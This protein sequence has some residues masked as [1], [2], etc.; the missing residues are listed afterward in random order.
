MRKL[1]NGFVFFL[2]GIVAVLMLVSFI[3]PYLSP[4]KYPLISILSLGVPILIVANIGFLIY[5]LIG[6]NRRLFLSLTVLVFSYFYFN[7]F[8]EYSIEGNPDDYENN[9][10]LLSYNVRLFNAF[11]KKDYGN[12]PEMMAKIIQEENPDVICIQEYYRNH[13]VDFSAFPYKFIHFRRKDSKV[14]YA[15]F[16]KY[17]LKNTG[18]FD[19]EGSYN[20][21]Q[22]ADV[23]LERDTIRLYNVHLQSMGIDADVRYLHD[24]DKERLARRLSYRFRLQEKQVKTLLKHKDESKYPAI[25]A[26]DMNNTPFSYTYRKLNTGMQDSFRERGRGLG[27]T[28]SFDGFPM[29]IDYIFASREYDVISFKTIKETFSDHHAI[30]VILGW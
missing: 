27:A 30:R 12:V 11:E 10:T 19:F 18:A 25:L 2:N 5:W 23:I 17:P 22:Y 13:K 16:S 20:N 7:V 29:R 15:I 8:Y 3:L 4:E 1:I 9:L 28:F 6:L 21:A 24:A 14:G 26:G